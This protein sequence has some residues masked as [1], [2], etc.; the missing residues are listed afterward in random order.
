MKFCC[1]DFKDMF[2]EGYIELDND[3]PRSRGWYG[4]EKY[5]IK[6]YS[7]K[8]LTSNGHIYMKY[9]PRCG[10]DLRISKNK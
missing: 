5:V 3:E 9:C 1:E 4:R 8:K 10:K 2:D 7:D 6:C